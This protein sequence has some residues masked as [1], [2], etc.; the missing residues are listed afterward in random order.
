MPMHD[1]TRVRAGTYHAFHYKWIDLL[2]DALNYGGLPKG[3]VALPEQRVLGTE[4]DVLTLQRPVDVG[5]VE[6]GGSVAV[7]E[8]PPKTRFIAESDIAN[9]ARR[10]NYLAIRHHEGEVVAVIEIMS[11]GNKHSELALESFVAKSVSLLTA[12]IH[13]LVVDP[14]PPSPRDPNGVHGEIWEQVGDTPFELPPDKRLTFASYASG[15]KTTAYVEP[16]AVGDPLPAMPLF[17]ME[18]KWVP[19]PLESSYNKAWDLFPLKSALTIDS[20]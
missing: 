4:P 12:G 7:L 5:S 11:P 15:A 10:A 9:F 13:L 16:I 20:R 8:T 14:F 17:L 18:G 2:S 1:W 19:C 6:A 3:Y